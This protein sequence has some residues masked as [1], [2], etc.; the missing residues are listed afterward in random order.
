MKSIILAYFFS[1]PLLLS[2]L[3]IPHVQ[4]VEESCKDPIQQYCSMLKPGQGRIYQCLINQVPSLPVE[5]S[6]SLAQLKLKSG[7][8]PSTYDFMMY[9]K[10]F[11]LSLILIGPI[12][13]FMERFSRTTQK[14]NLSKSEFFQDFS[15]AVMNEIIF[16]PIVVLSITAVIF[17]LNRNSEIFSN[18]YF[19]NSELLQIG[20][21]STIFQVIVVLILND[22]VGY[23]IHRLFHTDFFWKMH[24]IHHSP[25]T[26]TWTANLRN[27]PLNDVIQKFLQIVALICLGAPTK[28]LVS[29]ELILFFQNCFAHSIVPIRSG[30][31]DKLIVLP[32]FHRKHHEVAHQFKYG[33][34]FAGLLPIWDV[35]FGTADFKESE[36][37]I[38]GINPPMPNRFIDQL[39]Y[40]YRSRKYE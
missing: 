15:Y 12:L 25:E 26:L 33:C 40:P 36:N 20:K 13:F 32:R 23:W 10:A 4:S 27:H 5:C 30:W 11:C 28:I 37:P 14:R 19:K 6:K 9:L 7:W 39:L 18:F 35:L 8:L 24:A 21:L 34:N 2:L 31:W 17:F 38:Y 29:V 16:T 22:F 1:I 3:F